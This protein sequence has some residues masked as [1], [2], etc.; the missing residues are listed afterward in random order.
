MFAAFKNWPWCVWLLAAAV[1]C[2]PQN[3]SPLTPKAVD[4]LAA[5]P[6]W[7]EL[8]SAG[9][10]Y[11]VQFSPPPRSLPLN[12][13]FKMNVHVLNSADRK[14]V[15]PEVQL[16]VDAA[17]PAHRHGM[18]TRSKTTM[19]KPGEF[20]V[21]GMNLHMSGDWELYFDITRAGVTERAQTS[22]TLA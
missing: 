16:L 14:P 8:K 12:Q 22:V 18:T 11:I 13:L 4:A 15:G 10:T 21:R 6:D 7:T 5:H 9:G 17:M 1:A 20:T 2:Q 3:Q 19:N